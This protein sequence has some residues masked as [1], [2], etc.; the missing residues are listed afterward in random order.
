[1]DNLIQA[2]WSQGIDYAA[3]RNLVD[4]CVDEGRTTG[5]KQS[6]AL[7]HYTKL[8]A[9]RMK[10][11]DK[12]TQLTPALRERA[13][14]LQRRYQWLVLTEAWCGDAAQLLPLIHAVAA[15]SD[16]I[17]LRMV[18]RDEHD[19]LMQRYLTRG[20]RSIPKLIVHDADSGEERGSW[21]PRPAGA[22]ALVDELRNQDHSIVTERLQRWYNQDKNQEA[23][24]ELLDLLRGWEAS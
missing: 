2:K 14:Q 6:E 12:T 3:Y 18:L 10:R 23:Q 19:D 20:G 9:Q 8:N 4:T 5:P 7:V 15:T 21:G 13:S 16:R 17:A 1:M 11:L 24:Q 22:Q